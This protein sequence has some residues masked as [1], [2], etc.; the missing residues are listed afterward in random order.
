MRSTIN[1]LMAALTLLA[2][3]GIRWLHLPVWVAL[4]PFG[5]LLI[6]APGFFY[7][8]YQRWKESPTAKWKWI[9]G[10]A[11]ASFLAAAPL[12]SGAVRIEAEEPGERLACLLFYL[13]VVLLVFYLIAWLFGLAAALCQRQ[14]EK[15]ERNDAKHY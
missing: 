6:Q 7:A 11:A 12:L 13:A 1:R 15:E 10:A 2:S 4:L 9:I 5:L 14:E 8:L 3:L